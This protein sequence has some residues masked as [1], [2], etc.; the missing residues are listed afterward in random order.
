M[1]DNEVIT[2]DLIEL[3]RIFVKRWLIMLLAAV[4]AMGVYLGYTQFLVTPTYTSTATLYVLKQ[5]DE[6]AYEQSSST[7]TDFS[8]ALNVMK[9]CTYLLKSHSVLDRVI[10]NEN[11]SSSYTDLY[12]S[13]T[14]DNPTN[15][16]VLQV[17]VTADQP[18]TAKRV[19]DAICE[20]GVDR[21]EEAM[22]FRQV[23]VYQEGTLSESRSNGISL[24]MVLAIG[25]VA[26][27]VVYAL[28]VAIYLL[29]DSL[30]TDEEIEDRLGLTILGRIPDAGSSR[31]RRKK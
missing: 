28:F 16:R 21:I 24:K 18:E 29:D 3:W 31:H 15:T 19:V 25:L 26:A 1:N 30:R 20:I 17:T 9:D 14:T 6:D 8:L 7:A 12:N 11:L 2:K 13:I 27:V 10:L 22:G 5:Q 4:I 23:N